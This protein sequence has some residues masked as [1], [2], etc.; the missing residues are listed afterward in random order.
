MANVYEYHG[1][2]RGTSLRPS[3]LPK[4]GKRHEITLVER[5]KTQS[6]PPPEKE[7]SADG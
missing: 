2:G 5:L 7:K 4:R 1:K 3:L 6:Q